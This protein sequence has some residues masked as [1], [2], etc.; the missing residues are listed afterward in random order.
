MN[1]CVLVYIEK[2]PRKMNTKNAAFLRLIHEKLNQ[3]SDFDRKEKKRIINLI[4]DVMKNEN[5]QFA[6]PPKIPDGLK[7]FKNLLKKKNSGIQYDLQTNAKNPEE[8]KR[9]DEEM[10]EAWNDD[11]NEDYKDIKEEVQQTIKEMRDKHLNYL[12]MIL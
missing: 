8:L 12:Y 10:E 11:T 6:P 1:I 2:N 7:L 5:V 4:G 3:E 9:I